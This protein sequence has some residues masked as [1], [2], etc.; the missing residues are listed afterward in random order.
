VQLLL[1]PFLWQR[2]IR[3]VTNARSKLAVD[4]L[5]SASE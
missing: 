3:D 2:G 4:W 5:H 1:P